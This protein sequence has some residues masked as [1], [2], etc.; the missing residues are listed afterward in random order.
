M[1]L[2]CQAKWIVLIL[3]FAQVSVSFAAITLNIGDPAPRIQ[4][5]KWVQGEAVT[6]FKTN[7]TYLIEFWATWSGPSRDSVPRLNEIHN[8]FK[9]KGLVVIGINAWER[10]TS[11]IEPFI[12]EFGSNMTY[13]VAVDLIPANEKASDGKMAEAWMAASGEDTI[14]IDYFVDKEGKIAWIGHSIELEEKTIDQLVA[15][16]FNLKKASEERRKTQSAEQELLTLVGNLDSY[17]GSNDWTRAGV[18]VDEIEKRLKPNERGNLAFIRLEIAIGKGD[19]KAA[20]KLAMQLG[21]ENRESALI[22]NNLAWRMATDEN[23]KER[24][25][26]G[27][28]KL[29]HRANNVSGGKSP[30]ILN[31][32]ARIKFMQGDKKAAIELENKAVELSTERVRAGYQKALESFKT[33][34]L[35][36][37]E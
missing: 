17:M 7:H 10:D 2:C 9:D 19:S 23:L 31:T 14:P 24:D 4:V 33:D 15:G 36:P 37:V 11:K 6:E 13:R 25:L 5:S 1:K 22:Q 18:T 29:A 16:A 20:N 12:R 27:A 34:K 28:E 3:L 21:N 30:V 26:N 8:R 35:P 32:F